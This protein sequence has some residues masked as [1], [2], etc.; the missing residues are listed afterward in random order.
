[1][2]DTLLEV[3]GS[4]VSA[5]TRIEFVRRSLIGVEGSQVKFLGNLCAFLHRAL[6]CCLLAAQSRHKDH[7]DVA[8]KFCRFL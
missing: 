2:G 1:M 7:A 6:P 4:I 3:D 5:D 8:C